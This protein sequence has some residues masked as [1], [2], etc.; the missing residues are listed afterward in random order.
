MDIYALQTISNL[1][2]GALVYWLWEDTHVPKVVGSNPG[3]VYWMDIFHIY[4]LWNCVV[5]LKRPKI[6]QKEAGVGPFLKKQLATFPIF[7]MHPSIEFSQQ[8]ATNR[9]DPFPTCFI[10][11]I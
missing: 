1:R 11:G 2:A 9:K 7:A 6:N 3:T 4:L 10:L 8:I 5:C